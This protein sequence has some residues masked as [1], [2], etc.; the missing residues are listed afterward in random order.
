VLDYEGEWDMC[1]RGVTGCFLMVV[2]LSV[3]SACGSGDDD[4]GVPASLPPPSTAASEDR[5]DDEEPSSQT[6]APSGLDAADDDAVV[7]VSAELGADE[8]AEIVD[9]IAATFS[10]AEFSPVE[11]LLGDD[12]VWMALSG[13]DYDRAT[14]GP[15]LASFTDSSGISSYVVDVTRADESVEDSGGFWFKMSETLSNGK[16]RTFWIAIAR[17]D[18]GA[19]VVTER[20]RPPQS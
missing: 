5:T 20:L 9:E 1:G 19:L 8:A 10:V 6:S 7:G 4:S 17:N 14:V 11:E 18:D 16:E 13:E 3:G 2:G 12:G 15:F